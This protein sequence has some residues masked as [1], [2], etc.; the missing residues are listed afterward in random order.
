MI[1]VSNA[2][3]L[4]NLARIGRLEL[5]QDLFGE[6]YLPE[7]GRRWWWLGKASRGLSCWHRQSGS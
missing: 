3:P 1:F 5:L 6:V 2:S 4:V 7:S